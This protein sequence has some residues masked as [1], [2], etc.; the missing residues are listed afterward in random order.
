MG[1]IGI[2]GGTFNPIHNGHIML[3]DYCKT[4]LGLEKV[5]L[6]P[7][8]T[9]PHKSAE[10]LVDSFHRINMCKIAVSE[11]DGFEVSDIET[12]RMGK[13]YSFETLTSLKELYPNEE[14]YLIVGADMFLTLDKWKNPGVIFSKATI[15]AV[16]RDLSDYCEL[17]EFYN[18][19]LKPMG[20]N[21]VILPKPVLQV[22]SS[23]I[24]ANIE[25]PDIILPL[26]NE[27]VYTY[28]INN[29]LYR[30]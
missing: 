4:E 16:P 19:R 27:N 9:P 22:S 26:I 28:I 23:Y 11:Y 3:A 30:K 6:I 5:I 12:K 1:K 13:S 17:F 15:A 7:T 24:R 21:A 20:A 2:L 18:S 25:N 10:G 29:N 14:L 8:Y